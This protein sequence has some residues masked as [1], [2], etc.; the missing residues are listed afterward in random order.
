MYF[1][2]LR[3]LARRAVALSVGVS[4]LAICSTASAE[5]EIKMARQYGI[6]FLPYIVME[7]QKLIEK[8]AKENG[9]NDVKVTW[10]QFSGSGGMNDALLSGNLS[11]GAGA[12]PSLILLWARTKGTP[13]EVRGVSATNSMPVYLNTRNPA[14]KSLKDFT[15]KDKIALPSV[16]LSTAAIVLQMGAA[17]TFGDANWAQL[18]RLTV[19][20]SHP[21]AV[22]AIMSD[23]SE[24]NSHFASPPYQILELRNPRI[25]NV[26][27]SYDL[28]GDAS[29]TAVW[30]TKKYA[31]ANP[32][33][34]ATVFAAIKDAV[35]FITHDK[36]AAAELYLTVTKEKTPLA[37]MVQLLNDPRTIFT[38]VPQATMRFADFMNKTGTIKERPASWQDLFLP[39]AHKLPGT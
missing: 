39:I 15:D 24:V 11:F 27:T 21:D 16:K 38:N 3:A 8:R 7:Q 28:M 32:K 12:V 25:H 36:K 6:A 33:S 34:V 10:G 22:A 30:T 37:D 17:K 2:V 18:D 20:M 29:L 13:L 9:I 23:S 26:L 31:D 4:M 14:I 1:A 35:D 5:T 19:S